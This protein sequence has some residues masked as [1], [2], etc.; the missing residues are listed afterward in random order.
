MGRRKHGGRA[1]KNTESDLLR[2]EK[3]Y[4]GWSKEGGSSV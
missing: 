1:Q 4:E 2:G 3:E